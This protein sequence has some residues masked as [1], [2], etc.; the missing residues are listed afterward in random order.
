ML[1]ERPMGWEQNK[2]PIKLMKP[3]TDLV[4]TE[5]YNY[6]TPDFKFA[7]KAKDMGF[8][9]FIYDPNPGIEPLFLP[10]HFRIRRNTKKAGSMKGSYDVL[11]K[12]SKSHIFNGMINTSW[13]DSGLH[14][15]MWMLSFVVSAQ[16][17]WNAESPSLEEF[18]DSFFVSYYGK[19]AVDMKE[20]Y[21]LLND[22]A[23]Y[24]ASTFERNV[25]HHGIIG[26]THLP[27]LPRGQY[28]EYDQYWNS[29]YKDMVTKSIKQQKKMERAFQ[30]IEAN[31]ILDLD[32]SYDFELYASIAAL[33]EHTSLTY[34]DLSNLE[35]TITAAH[36]N[37]FIDRQVAYDN[38]VKAEQ[39]IE[40]SLERRGNIF[41]NLT[42]IWEKTR[43]P[44]GLSTSD[45]Q[46]FHKMDRSRH[47]ANRT[48]DLSY[49][50]YD[51]QLL[52]MEGYLQ[53]LREYRKS[54]QIEY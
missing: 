35:N 42:M 32:H 26:K 28:I 19:E 54:F 1:W 25:W 3:D 53:R 51:E 29:E 5:S 9:L 37:A 27:D 24:Y 47:F 20:L 45:K 36:R 38:L 46:Y 17:S 22:G 8:E 30:I 23:Y 6:E 11:T 41:N 34:M 15:Q 31:K 52:N 50:I 12:A 40:K 18:E 39:L 44:K 4:L 10:Y 49:L 43:L 14:N 21:D 2:S 33:I 16:Y 48:A 13:D 7:Q